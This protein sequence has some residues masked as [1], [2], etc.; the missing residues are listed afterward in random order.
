MQEELNSKIDEFDWDD[1]LELIAHKKVVPIVGSELLIVIDAQSNKKELLYGDQ[2]YMHKELNKIKSLQKNDNFYELMEINKKEIPGR[3][4]IVLERVKDK[5]FLDPLK[6]L[7]QITDFNYYIST[8]YD[9]FFEDTLQAER[10]EKG[11]QI[12][13][14]DFSININASDDSKKNLETEVPTVFNLMGS[15]KKINGFAKTEEEILEHLYSLNEHVNEQSSIAHSLFANV[16]Q[17]HLLFLGC[18]FPNW[19]LRFFIRILTNSRI[20]DAFLTKIIADCRTPNDK[21]LCMFLNHFNSKI[22]PVHDINTVEFV[23]KLFEKWKLRKSKAHK[24]KYNG[25]VF[26]SYSSED[27][28]PLVNELYNKLEL[29]GVNVFYDIKKINAGDYFDKEITAEIKNCK[30]FIPLIS[31]NSLDPERYVIKEWEIAT[32]LE[33]LDFNK[34]FIIPF[35]IDNTKANDEMIRKNF[36]H[37]SVKPE[38]NV[39]NIAE[40]I[41]SKLEPLDK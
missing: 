19:L 25:V 40:F 28:E 33:K 5:M 16:N 34:E 2:N 12:R 36:K 20:S 3:I 13:T 31:K 39:N 35:I 41:I 4:Q 14:I 32:A 8:T 37:I 1:L 29:E 27:R 7:A 30:L 18:C 17:K 15:S 24:I 23:D 6:K 22:Y 9:S 21:N 26:L 11:E 38:N 10:C